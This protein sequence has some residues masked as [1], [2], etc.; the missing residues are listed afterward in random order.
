MK[1]PKFTFFFPEQWWESSYGIITYIGLNWFTMIQLWLYIY[2][3]PSHGSS[4]AIF[5]AYLVKFKG[6]TFIIWSELQMCWSGLFAGLEFHTFSDLLIKSIA[7][8]WKK[9]R[10]LLAKVKFSLAFSWIYFPILI[11]LSSSV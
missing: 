5:P 3:G 2:F 4:V 9:K 6:L 7:N 8:A 10:D 11:N 1:Q